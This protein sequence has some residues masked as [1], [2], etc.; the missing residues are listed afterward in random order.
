MGKKWAIY[1][2]GLLA[3]SANTPASAQNPNLMNMF[4][5]I[6][7]AAIV[8]NART[9]W[10]K[11]PQ[12]ETAC[13]EQEL[14]Q[15]RASI[16][17]LIQ[18]GIV[19]ND[20]RVAGVRF[21]CRT[22]ALGPATADQTPAVNNPP[23]TDISKLSEKP[24]FDCSHAR[25]LTAR[26]VCFD[27]AGAMADWD[28]IT[29]Y[30]A[31]YF[32]LP[33]SERQAFDNAQQ[34]WLDSLNQK[35]PRTSN[36]PQCVLA[37]YHSRAASYRSQLRG[38]ALA[39]SHLTPE[40]HA[41]IQQSLISMGLLSDS[42][43]GE[44]GPNTRVAIRQYRGQS[45]DDQGEF[46]TAPQRAQLLQ[47]NSIV[48]TSVAT[49]SFDCSRATAADERLICGNSRLAQ[50]DNVVAAGYEY[51]VTHYGNA[52]AS[53]LGRPLLQSRQA[54]GA[55]A[56]CIEQK[57]LAAI[58]EYQ[59]LGAP[60]VE[61]QRQTPIPGHPPNADSEKSAPP[62]P[63]ITP[64]P[65]RIETARLKQAR[66]FLDDTKQF[67]AQQNSV[68]SISEIAKE[69][70]T[71]QVAL[72]QFDERSAI[73]SMQRLNDLLKPVSGFAEFEQQQQTKR[74]REEARQLADGRTLAKQNE[75]FIDSYLQG[76]LGDSATQP[77]LS[78]RQEID[79]AV[80]ANTMEKISKAN[81]A[82]AAYVNTNGLDAV[83]AESAK[84][85][86]VPEHTIPHT[87]GTLRDSL[88]ERSKFLV[89]GSPDE[90]L[91]LYNASPTAPKVWKNVR[92]DVVFQDDAA[93]LCFAQPSVELPI[94]RYVE[95][96]LGDLGAK[97]VDVVDP[98]CDLS[99]AVKAVDIVAFQRGD[100][101]KS[102]EDYVLALAKLLEADLF[103][104]YKTITNYNEEVRDRQTLS[105]KIESDLENGLRKGFG[106]ISVIET[107]VAC[108]IPPSKADWSDGLKELLRKDADVIAPTLTTGWQ[109]VD[110][111]S[112]DLA[113]RGLQRRQCGYLLADD[114]SL[115]AMMLALRREQIKYVFA[116]VWW[117]G[118]Q[119]EQATFDAHDVVQQEIL[120]KKDIERKQRDDQALQE[121][122]D[123]DKQNQKTEIER[124]YR[125]ANS[126]KARG[127][128]N[129]VQDLVSGMAEKR[130]V[131]NA[132]LFPAYS[133]WLD[134]R[135]VDKW[136]TFN[137]SS[138]VADFGQ[139]Q[140]QGRPLDAVV[141]RTIVQQKNRI[142]G[143]YEDRCFLFGF[144]NDDEFDVLRD[145]FAWDCNDTSE[146]RK[147]EVGERFQSRW[148]AD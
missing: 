123:K 133:G 148:N 63:P 86:A 28:L 94:A 78:L 37:A 44:F 55:A 89:E 2:A 93:V 50:L 38:D 103:R 136:E 59:D 90:I 19:P 9:E 144:V 22:A 24:T 43:D 95:H 84:K 68:Q 65:P 127:L 99:H 128:M 91:L 62:P 54:C 18:N 80:K 146:L 64:P 76:H 119:V 108:V 3:W 145:S 58:K 47:A 135:F 71:L 118:N 45:A 61:P 4:T 137:V 117:D 97:K 147:W 29:A 105:L 10:S 113:F 132:D 77:L 25:S 121:Q 130:A 40:Q 92:G 129:Y 143:K 14:H 6:M 66:V 53:R 12:D 46:L 20:P 36:P 101:L 23:P 31:R 1:L 82:V 30:W 39:E 7:G 141:V 122:R 34:D 98:P 115:K 107:P 33:E 116:P 16:G 52:E 120:K 15:Q 67:I 125:A 56:E 126:A 88:T 73:E 142:L 140:W 87:A 112:T 114:S 60:I 41:Q 13:I 69:A 75:F 124:K 131:K 11:V 57:Q 70:A 21:D 5:T 51:V 27:R 100:L 8:N 85:F 79:N 109:F 111:S 134:G 96:Y 83:Y 32:S 102:R 104:Q 49:P 35:C 110:T 72:N 48:A 139:V 106:A 81:E 42:P 17:A 138:D 74:N 26:T